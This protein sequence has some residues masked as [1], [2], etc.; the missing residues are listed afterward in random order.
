M[1]SLAKLI[2]TTFWIVTLS[3]ARSS[4]LGMVPPRGP[5]CVPGRGRR[6]PFSRTPTVLS[7][8]ALAD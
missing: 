4:V 7:S 6:G 8:Q 5:E 3:S 1:S 2:P